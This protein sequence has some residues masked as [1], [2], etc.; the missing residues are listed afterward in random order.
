MRIIEDK[1]RKDGFDWIKFK[2]ATNNEANYLNIVNDRGCYSEVGKIKQN[3]SQLLSLDTYTGC[4]VKQVVIHELVHALMFHHEHKRPDRDEYIQIFK[5]NID[6][7]KLNAVFY[8][9]RNSS[10]IN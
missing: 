6:Q 8:K 1:T 4:V 3:K 9:L 7:S 5:E 10:V 2:H